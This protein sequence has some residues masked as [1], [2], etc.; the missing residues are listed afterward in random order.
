MTDRGGASEGPPGPRNGNDRAV[1][2]VNGDLFKPMMILSAP[3]VAAQLLQ[4]GY[5]LADTYWVGRLGADPVAA[6]SYSW[7]IVFLMVSVGG[8]LTVAGTVLVAQYKGAQDFTTTD[9][10]AGQTLS[11]V[12]IIAAGFAAVGILLAP[13]L[14][15]LVGATPGTPPH[16]MAVS[17]TRI[18]FLGVSFMFW[19]FIFDALSRGWGDTRTPLYLM[20]VSVVINVVLDPFLIL[21][22]EENPIFFWFGLESLQATLFA[23]TGFAGWGIEGAAVATLFARGLAAVAGLYLLFTGKVGL[24][25]QLGDLVLQADT[26]R[27]IIDIGGPIAIE[28]GMRAGGLAILTAVIAIAGDDAVAAYGIVNRLSTLLFLPALGLSR[29]I[30]TVVGQNLGARQVD[31]AKHAVYLGSAVVTGVFI[32]VIAGAYPN[33]ESIIGFF[34]AADA[35]GSVPV[36]EVIDIGALYI[37]IVGPAYVFLGVF[38]VLL[39]AIRGS[40]STRAAMVLSIQ[41]L[42]LWRLPLAYGL[43]AV[44]SLGIVGVWYAVAVSYIAATIITVVWFRRGTWTSSIVEAHRGHPAD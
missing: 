24:Q 43:I 19:F 9:H 6:L 2:V 37:W 20:I 15:S 31:R 14:I 34:L 29:G 1:D 35:A 44:A 3:I 10:V 18:I 12:T 42:W 27:S 13:W 22:F 41:E 5:N 11:F 39:G 25:P 38:Q 32:V 17:Y 30:E 28:Q 33:A 4:V 36:E 40:G 7:A 8:G 23:A 16:R 21:G 26:V